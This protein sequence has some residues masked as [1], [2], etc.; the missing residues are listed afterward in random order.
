MLR[1]VISRLTARD[2]SI[3][4]QILTLEFTRMLR[5]RLLLP[6]IATTRPGRLLEKSS[7]ETGR[8]RMGK[9]SPM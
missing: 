8:R 9:S 4:E 5:R 2:M 6:K 3:I 1:R 7:E